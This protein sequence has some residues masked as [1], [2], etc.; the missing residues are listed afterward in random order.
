MLVV[1]V[2]AR[3]IGIGD[4][5]VGE[6]A[7]GLDAVREADGEEGEGEIGGG[8][9]G[10]GGEG[11]TAVP[12]FGLVGKGKGMLRYVEVPGELGKL[13]LT[14]SARLKLCN[15][16]LARLVTGSSAVTGKPGRRTRWPWLFVKCLAVCKSR[17]EAFMVSS[18]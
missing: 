2:Y 7:Q 1:G 9:E 3:N 8:E 11:R 15:G 4:D 18:S 13:Y 14:R 10:F 12:G 6:V 5:D 16:L 17:V